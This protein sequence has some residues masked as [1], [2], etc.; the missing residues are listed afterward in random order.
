[1][2]LV[3]ILIGIPMLFYES[4]ASARLID[5]LRMKI[6][7]L[8]IINFMPTLLTDSVGIIGIH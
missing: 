4:P 7:H 8:T 5:E 2:S 3:E 6:Y 1:M